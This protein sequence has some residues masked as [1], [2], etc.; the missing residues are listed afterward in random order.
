[1]K[2]TVMGHDNKMSEKLYKNVQEAVRDLEIKA[3]IIYLTDIDEIAKKGIMKTPALMI[4]ERVVSSGEVLEASDI[5]KIL[6]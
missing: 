6:R 1:M 3:K 5:K 4:D 2:V